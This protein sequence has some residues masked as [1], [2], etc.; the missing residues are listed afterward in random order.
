MSAAVF[1]IPPTASK[2]PDASAAR[3]RRRE[4]LASQRQALEMA[5]SST[6]KTMNYEENH[7]KKVRRVSDIS[8]SGNP[9]TPQGCNLI[10]A[11]TNKKSTT[12]KKKV[13]TKKKPQ[14]KYDPDV[15]MSKEDAAAWRRE[16]RRKRN[17]ESAAL[18]RQRQRDRIGDLEV[19]VDEWKSKVE[20]IMERIKRLEETSGVDSQTL[21]S[22]TPDKH[23]D[24]VEQSLQFEVLDD[25]VHQSKFVSPP[26]SPGHTP[27]H[28][29][30]KASQI[31]SSSAKNVVDAVVDQVLMGIESYEQEFSDNMISRHAVKITTVAPALPFLPKSEDSVTALPTPETCLSGD[32]SGQSVPTPSY[33]TT[34]SSSFAISSTTTLDPIDSSLFP[35]K[36]EEKLPTILSDEENE[37]EFGEFLLDA[38]QWL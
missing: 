1:V 21:V 38:V 9:S 2:F 22:E 12:I 13:S 24:S 29:E 16:Q 33:N 37:D 35:V 32:V 27:L 17:R 10:A 25:A 34:K 11:P 7:V 36:E 8:D 31:L 3:K 26:P 14:M 23:D 15:P 6:T 28:E 5:T 4:I 20:T 18:S 19:E 30:P